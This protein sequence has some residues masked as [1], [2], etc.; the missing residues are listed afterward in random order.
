LPIMVILIQITKA[1][2]FFI[3][4]RPKIGRT[5]LIPFA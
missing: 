3:E 4:V 2:P 1:P 5:S